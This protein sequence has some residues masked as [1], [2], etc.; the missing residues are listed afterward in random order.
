MSSTYERHEPAHLPS[1]IVVRKQLPL[2][3]YRSD[4]NQK[5]INEMPP[6]AL[7]VFVLIMLIHP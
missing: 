1:H 2:L 6:S 7:Y 5:G 4:R 3:G